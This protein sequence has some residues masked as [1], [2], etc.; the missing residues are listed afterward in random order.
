[1]QIH[2]QQFG[3][4]LLSAQSYAVKFGRPLCHYRSI[5]RN[6]E[7]LYSQ[8]KAVPRNLEPI[9][10]RWNEPAPS[11]AHFPTQP[12]F[13]CCWEP[14]RNGRFQGGATGVS[15][16]LGFEFRR[17]AAR[18]AGNAGWIV[19]PAL[20][21]H[22]QLLGLMATAPRTSLRS[23]AGGLPIFMIIW[24]TRFRFLCLTRFFQK[25]GY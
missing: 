6:S 14:F 16:L 2:F 3:R 10:T 9:P 12:G 4:H 7:G 13:E 20:P 23:P 18:G 19:G 21:D 15:P 24:L 17:Y 8:H 5:P 25:Y 1:M 22:Q 11:N